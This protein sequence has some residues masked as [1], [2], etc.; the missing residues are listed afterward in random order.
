MCIRDSYKNVVA[1]DNKKVI[2]PEMLSSSGHRI[3][4]VEDNKIN[5][6]VVAK[7][8]T[9]IGMQVVTANNGL[10]ALTEIKAQNFDLILMD[11][12]MP[13]MD[14]YR[15]TSEIRKMSDPMKRDVPIIA[16]TASAF[17]TEKEKAKLFGMNDHVGKPFSP[18]DLMEKIKM[19]LSIYHK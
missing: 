6:I 12:Q 4:V 15:A 2:S 14:G 10:E 1:N 13:K 3:L 16:L 18:E 9:K 11:I 17:L 8:L 5:Q 19:C 7:M